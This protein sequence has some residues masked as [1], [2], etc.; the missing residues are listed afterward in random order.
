MTGV[1][2]FLTQ[3]LQSVLGYS[4][5]QAGLGFIPLA[6]TMM[7]AAPISARLDARYRLEGDRRRRLGHR[8][9]APG[10]CCPRPGPTPAYLLVGAVLALLGAGLGLRHDPGHQLDHGVAAP[11]QG[12]GRLGG[13]RHHPPDRRA[14]GVAILGSIT[15]AV[16]R[17]SVQ[18][19]ASFR[20]LSA[21]ARATVRGG[22]GNVV[23]AAN[24][25]PTPA[26]AQ[27][28]VDAKRSFVHAMDLTALIGMLFV[29]AGAT[30]A[31]IW[32]PAKAADEVSPAG[33]PSWRR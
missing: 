33:R 6:V 13:Q 25:L 32:L 21:A 9:A 30:V 24:S 18:S 29:L 8:R 31:F 16:Y 28:S 7:I 23:V 11:G 5:L 20:T 14:L 1:L 19:T 10:S 22:I 27:L 26:R 3:Y 12:R 4:A 15:D 2:F 17:S